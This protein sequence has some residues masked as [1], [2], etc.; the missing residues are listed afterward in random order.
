[1]EGLT[2]DERRQW[3]EGTIGNWKVV[4][5]VYDQS[6]E[7][8]VL[9][10]KAAEGREGTV[11]GEGTGSGIES[12]SDS[13]SDGEERSGSSSSSSTSNSG[14]AESNSKPTNPTPQHLTKHSNKRKATSIDEPEESLTPKKK[15]RLTIT[16]HSS[17]TFQTEPIPFKTFVAGNNATASTRP[18]KIPKSKKKNR[19]TAQSVEDT[20]QKPNPAP[21]FAALQAHLQ[22]EVTAGL[23]RAAEAAAEEARVAMRG[24]SKDR[25][26]RKR[27]SIGG[28]GIVESKKSRAVGRKDGDEG[29]KEEQQKG[30]DKKRKAGEVVAYVDG[31]VIVPLVVAPGEGVERKKM[32]SHV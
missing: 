22:A 4:C 20:V 15:G 16:E 7:L 18:I 8:L 30:S 9:A 31:G 21:D 12:N 3:E 24:G 5:G 29:G 17:F 25:K 6:R 26:K 23:A 28:E 32:K 27:D 1:M 14:T 10:K 19:E 11:G 2:L 13:D